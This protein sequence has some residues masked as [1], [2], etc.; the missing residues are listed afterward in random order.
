MAASCLVIN[1]QKR[2]LRF[3]IQSKKIY[4]F[5]A[6]NKQMIFLEMIPETYET[7]MKNA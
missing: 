5:K 6:K 1:G 2:D 4:L 3:K 7:Q